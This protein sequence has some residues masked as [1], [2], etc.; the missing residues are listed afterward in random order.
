MPDA[1]KLKAGYT[2]RVAAGMV[3]SCWILCV[4][5]RELAGLGDESKCGMFEELIEKVTHRF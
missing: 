2:E 5:W 3:Q 1:L 4:F